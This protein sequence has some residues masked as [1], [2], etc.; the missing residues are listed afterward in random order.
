[1]VDG[2][3]SI[4]MKWVRERICSNIDRIYKEDDS[5]EA[6][7]KLGIDAIVG[8]AEFMDGKTL[9]VVSDDEGKVSYGEC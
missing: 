7:Q 6:L 5:P 4:D 8:R 3:V 9:E 1:M 2:D